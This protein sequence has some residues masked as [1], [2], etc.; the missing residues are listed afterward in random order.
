MANHLV[1][2]ATLTGARVRLRAPHVED[3]DATFDGLASDPEV[4]R[5][6][7]WIPH[8]GVDETRR[9]VTKLFNVGDDPTWLIETR[10]TGEF[11]GTCGWIRP[12]PHTARWNLGIAWVAGGGGRES[13]RRWSRC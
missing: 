12:T 4:T 11:V 9:V 5:Y 10:D 6:L 7:S 13:C 3:A 1:R 2:P 8:R